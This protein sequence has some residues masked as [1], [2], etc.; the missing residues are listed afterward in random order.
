M[1]KDGKRWVTVPEAAR[2][3]GLSRGRTWELAA[4]GELPAI[5]SGTRYYIDIV[6]L[7]R[8]SVEQAA[9]RRREHGGR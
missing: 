2:L 5:R 6:A 9:A 3:L 8:L 1:D 7:D 4:R